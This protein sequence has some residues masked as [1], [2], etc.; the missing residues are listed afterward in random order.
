MTKSRRPV[1]VKDETLRDLVEA[2]PT[3]GTADVLGRLGCSRM[4]VER[5]LRGLLQGTANA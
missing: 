3:I 5:H 2:G 4:T 1:E